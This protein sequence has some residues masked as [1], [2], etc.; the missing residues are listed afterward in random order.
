MNTLTL[1][2]P[3]T[4]TTTLQWLQP[5]TMAECRLARARLREEGVL[6]EEADELERLQTRHGL[7]H[8]I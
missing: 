1:V 6:L 2:A 5:E 3:M 8:E 4:I 7:P